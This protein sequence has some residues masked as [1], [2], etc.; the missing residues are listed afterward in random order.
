MNF[1]YDFKKYEDDDDLDLL[2]FV[3]VERNKGYLDNNLIL[4]DKVVPL[5]DEAQF[6]EH[7][8]VSR[9]V[10]KQI[11]DRYKASAIYNL[12]TYGIYE[13]ISALH[14]VQ[15]FL[16]FA[17]H[18]SASYRD[19]SDRFDITL[20]SLHRIIR[21]VTSFLSCISSEFIKWPNHEEKLL[22]AEGFL[23]KGFPNVIGVIDGCHIRINKPAKDSRSFLNRKG[24]CS[25]NMQAVCNDQ[26]KIIDVFIGC[27]GSVHDARVFRRSNLGL[28]LNRKC[29]RYFLLGDAANPLKTNLMTP[30]RNINSLTQTQKHFNKKLNSAR[31]TIE[32]T[33]GIKENFECLQRNQNLSR[34]NIESSVEDEVNA[35]EINARLLRDQIA[36][37]LL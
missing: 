33:F 20:S 32:H 9:N 10:C 15:I 31:S 23:Q 1:F 26:N 14:Q 19:V 27:P 25:I 4:A 28:N 36:A 12:N 29:G 18:E 11:S 2:K 16:W 34:L 7:F 30:F 21:R 35:E 3:E 13:K 6:M 22:I 5:Y 24:Y 37:A 17:G 8:R